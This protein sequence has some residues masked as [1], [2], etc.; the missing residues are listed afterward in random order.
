MS[1]ND[2]KKTTIRPIYTKILVFAGLI[3]VY[4]LSIQP[5][6]YFLN[7]LM[8]HYRTEIIGAV[9]E[10]TGLKI[11]YSSM[12]PAIFGSFDIRELKATN[13]D[14]PVADI[15]NISVKF[16]VWQL[17]TNR[18][19]F[20][21]TVLIDKP[22]LLID[23]ERDSLFFENLSVWLE[24][25]DENKSD[26]VLLQQM[27]QFLPKNIDYQIREGYFRLIDK[28]RVYLVDRI[29]INIKGINDEIR[30]NGEIAAEFNYDGFNDM[31]I[32]VRTDA[33]INAVFSDDLAK[34]NANINVSYIN[35]SEKDNKLI[36]SILPFNISG[37]YDE[38][39]VSAVSQLE[40]GAII[41]NFHYEF[42]TRAV[43]A[44]VSFDNFM[45]REVINFADNWN[46]YN[47]LLQI[48]INGNSSF[49]FINKDS[50]TYNLELKGNYQSDEEMFTISADGNEKAVSINN[51]LISSG[52]GDM[53]FFKGSA[54]FKGN[55][56]FKELMPSGTLFFNNFTLT[57]KEHFS[58]V[59]NI[60][61]RRNL[62]QITSDNV[63]LARAHINDFG[64]SLYPSDRDMGVSV[65]GFGMDTGLFFLDAVY[66]FDPRQLEASLIIDSMT[67]FELSEYARPFA[68]YI[69]IPGSREILHSGLINTEIFYSTDF[70]DM[71]FNAPNVSFIIG[72]IYGML[73]LMGS[74]TR[75]ILSESVFYNG[76]DEFHVSAD[77]NYSNPKDLSFS[78]NAGFQELSW[79]INGQIIENSALIISDP[80]GLHVY[81]N[82]SNSGEISGY[83]ESNDYPISVNSNPIYL[84]FYS[85]LL[86]DSPELWNVNIN[87]FKA[88]SFS[89]PDSGDLL[90]ISGIINQ[91]G[92]SFRELVYNDDRGFLVGSADFSW[93]TDFSSL[94]F[95]V[96]ITDTL[97]GGEHYSIEGMYK[98]GKFDLGASISDMYVNRFVK[99][100][101]PI[102]LSADMNVSWESIESFAAKIDLKSF[103]TRIHD[104][105][106]KVAVG[107]NLSN[108]ELLINDLDFYFREVNAIIPEFKISRKEG[109]AKTRADVHG[110]MFERD[111][112]GFVDI[113]LI[114]DEFE[115]WLNITD[116]ARNFDGKIVIS[117]LLYG[118]KNYEDIVFNLAGNDGAYSINGGIKNMIRLEIDS[119]GSVFAGLS[120]PFPIQGTVIGTFKDW[121]IDLYAK[122]F[123]LDLA[124]L[125]SLVSAGKDFNIAGGYLTGEMNLLGPVWNPQFFG[126]CIGSS[127]RFEAP[128]YISE[129][130]RVVPFQVFAEGYEMT[131]GPVEIA[132]GSGMGTV[133]GWLLFENWSPSNIGINISIPRERPVPYN[134]NITGFL[135]NG[136][137]S[138]DLGMLVDMENYIIGLK[139]DLFTNDA[140]LGLNMDEL[141]SS[142][143]V[144]DQKSAKFNAIVEL[145]IITGSM[146]EFIWPTTSPMLKANPEMGALFLVTADTEARHYSIT[147]DVKIRSGEIFYFD[148]SFFIR[149]G[150][151]VLRENE[152][153]FNP[154]FSARAEIRDRID[155]G[156]VTISMIVEHQPLLSF[157]PRF[158]SNPGLTQ[159]E[160]YSILGQN[161][162]NLQGGENTEAMQRFILSS[163][164][165]IVT[166]IIA[167]TPAYSQVAFFRQFEKQMRDFLGLDMFSVRTR[168]IQNAVV[169]AGT[170]GFGP[171]EVDG[172]RIGFSNLFDNTTVFIGKYI[173]QH[174]FIHG[175]LTMRYD[176]NSMLFGGITFEPDIGI[177]LQTPF[178]NI[179]W[180]FFPKHP[181]NLWVSD[182]SIT[183]S[184]SKSF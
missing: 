2:G 57:G 11:R 183:L 79:H 92:A 49:N 74:D 105:E 12:R 62:I 37:T 182:N 84:N 176:E 163:S 19:A 184:W 4:T 169:Q 147:S 46:E 117:D 124:S 10:I 181:E 167:S 114:F 53:D 126:T 86:Y 175:M 164:A 43:N 41:T 5:L 38:K 54:G 56:N 177:E 151:L 173:G 100:G 95:F 106:I 36:F 97:E 7:R 52:N 120:A 22:V 6:Q 8:L 94:G 129:D 58:A 81:G 40:N 15:K 55:V 30:L 142:R 93:D 115:S 146:V 134:F 133:N 85:T 149:E 174:M 73:S 139:G 34:G 125:F 83:I 180:D 150:T 135:A 104:Y 171:S 153:G 78:L 63:T 101:T 99:W 27:A 3:A 24:T 109:I 1:K 70:K 25:R 89:S 107:V 111:F 103:N 16:S 127:I 156:N 96:N 69:N 130:I 72:D 165:D 87:H 50:F 51:F 44:Q 102:R 168:F 32:T 159:L 136:H 59:F 145:S 143:T 65:S 26:L 112:K 131:F 17:I 108:D 13:A 47:S 113:D 118:E 33:D 144:N 21:H 28:E 148:R 18:K 161:L 45:L 39:T 137:A 166:Q 35:C 172:S 67:F 170:V 31:T 71:I 160:I 88:R 29:D 122:N 119:D 155:T 64:I 178:V 158:E 75:L 152:T 91:N 76:Q 23:T 123:Y 179:R 68:D 128:G 90:S 80:N 138:G 121:N 61:S 141:S 116:A 82:I 9:E 60:S 20:V 157:Q 77:V 48:N 98:D 140:E 42:D 14:E 132:S 66:S 162:A 110:F 154:L